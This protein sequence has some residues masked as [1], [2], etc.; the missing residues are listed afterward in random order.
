MQTSRLSLFHYDVVRECC[1]KCGAE[2][3][4]FVPKDAEPAASTCTACGEERKIVDLSETSI[5]RLVSE[6]REI[7]VVPSVR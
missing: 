4:H 5:R 2:K 1:E 3:F 7:E 6:K